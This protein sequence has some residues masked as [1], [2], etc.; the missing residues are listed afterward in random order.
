MDAVGGSSIGYNPDPGAMMASRLGADGV[1][2]N[3]V[4]ANAALVEAQLVANVK[5]I[6]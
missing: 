5:W 2:N 6:T 4:V 3:S 1:E